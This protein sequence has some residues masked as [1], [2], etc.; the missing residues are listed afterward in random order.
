MSWRDSPGIVAVV[1]G[2]AATAF[3]VT[4]CFSVV[5]PTWLKSKNFEIEQLNRKI[6]GLSQE[7]DHERQKLNSERSERSN[8]VKRLVAQSEELQ[9]KLTELESK[10]LKLSILNMFSKDDVYP[11]GLRLVR[12]FQ[13][14]SRIKEVYSEDEL[15]DTGS[16][17]SVDTG[18]K[19]FHQATYYYREFKGQE[20]ITHILFHVAEDYRGTDLIY[21]KL[22]E[23]FGSENSE[24]V[25]IG[26]DKEWHFKNVLNHYLKVGEGVYVIRP[27]WPE[28]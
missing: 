17:Y 28:K 26:N 19:I 13:P 2:S 21:E 5:I 22:V 14:M 27:V 25:D 15:E 11:N 24:L 8:E 23:K 9:E 1:S 12:I 7:L 6:G 10:N 18:N 4:L 16:W 3:V 20:F